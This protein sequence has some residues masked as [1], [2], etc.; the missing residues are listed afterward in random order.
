MKTIVTIAVRMKSTRLPQKALATI[1]GKPLIRHLI[2]RVKKAKH[3]KTVVL[4][5]SN[6]P[7]DAILLE[8]AKRCAVPSLAGDA[9]NVLQRFELAALRE[10]AD[11]VVRV[12]GDNPLTDPEYIDRLIERHL[13]EGNE[14]T[15]VE[16]LPLGVAS[17]VIAVKALTKARLTLK[18]PSKSE[19][20]TF[21]L[22]D[23]NEYQIGILQADEA[24]KRPHYRLTVDTHDDLELMKVIYNN[25]YRA[26]EVF[27]LAEVV[28]FMDANPN[29]AKIN[30][31]IKQRIL[32][33]EEC[34]N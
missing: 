34:K 3:P 2:D 33:N 29:L 17:E 19:Y 26:E 28:S 31:K 9:D 6:L 22:K 25:L 27:S 24:V 14:Y 10:G 16:G 18:D 8:E 7:E 5:T 20:M 23:P 32:S 12:T 15:T 30:S 4:C 21:L 1:V 13:E 11:H